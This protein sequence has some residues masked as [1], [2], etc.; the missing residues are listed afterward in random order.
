MKRCRIGGGR[1]A[2]FTF[3]LLVSLLFFLIIILSL[4]WV[5][6]VASRHMSEYGDSAARQDMLLDVSTL[7]VKTP[8][9]PPGWE[10]QD[11]VT[12]GNVAALGLASGENV[13]D[14]AK[15]GRMAQEDY[16]ELRKIMGFGRGDFRLT[17]TSNF[18]GSPVVLC[19]QG[20]EKAVG[21][22]RVVRRYALLNG[23]RV[24]VKLE[25]F[26]AR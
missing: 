21:E 16:G 26:Y 15:V 25:E 13:L 2:L 20:E 17:V 1:G 8:G 18:S 7:L 9:N 3:D 12:A 19:S 6:S 11:T 4:T 23:T 22:K 10:L 24:E 5:W 14:P